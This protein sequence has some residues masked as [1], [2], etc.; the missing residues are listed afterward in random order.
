MSEGGSRRGV[1]GG[2][3][4]LGLGVVAL[5]LALSFP[6]LRQASFR[7]TT[8]QAMLDVDAVR[9]AAAQSFDV[10]GTWPPAAEVGMTPAELAPF[11]PTGVGMARPRYRLQWD[12]WE[13]VKPPPPVVPPELPTNLVD[14]PRA[15]EPI[16]TPGPVYDTLVGVTVHSGDPRL[17]AVLLEHYG[18]DHSFVHDSTW[19]LVLRGHE[20]S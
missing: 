16:A 17:L 11:L 3:V 18:S 9:G 7:K 5:G 10:K 4:M 1:T 13:T 20:G 8:A 19:T 2:D 15:V 14:E 12:R 6:W